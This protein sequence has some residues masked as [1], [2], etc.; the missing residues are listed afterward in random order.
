M[1]PFYKGENLWHRGTGAFVAEVAPRSVLFG[2]K[3]FSASKSLL[4]TMFQYSI[5]HSIHHS[6]PFN[7]NHSGHWQTSWLF[8]LFLLVGTFPCNTPRAPE[9]D[10]CCPHSFSL[11]P[12]GSQCTHSPT[13]T[14]VKPQTSPQA[15][16]FCF[17]SCWPPAAPVLQAGLSQ[18]LHCGSGTCW[19]C[20]ARLLFES[21]Q[22]F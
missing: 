7:F 1:S 13:Q 4:P 10:L 22:N 2:P 6:S 20:S 18:S 21:A 19:G 9:T 16:P 17:L 12:G 3:T 14:L 8:S 5:P 15:A 11:H